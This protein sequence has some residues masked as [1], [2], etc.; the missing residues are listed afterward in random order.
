METRTTTLVP[1]HT[2]RGGKTAYLRHTNSQT[3]TAF[4]T[5]WGAPSQ[6]PFRE[7]HRTIG[8]FNGV[9]VFPFDLVRTCLT[10]QIQNGIDIWYSLVQ[11]I[12][13][14]CVYKATVWLYCMLTFR[15][16]FRYN[17]Y[18]S[19]FETWQRQLCKNHIYITLQT[20]NMNNV[21]TSL[22]FIRGSMFCTFVFVVFLFFFIQQLSD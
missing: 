4:K 8:L 5:F 2:Q 10:K 12:H 7:Q 18:L 6:K 15:N 22:V 13:A 11:Q 9:T 3:E 21:A 1:A 14:L 16:E 20:E 17:I 19:L